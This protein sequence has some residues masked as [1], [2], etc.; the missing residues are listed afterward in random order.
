MAAAG[1]LGSDRAGG[2]A[3]PV[4]WLTSKPEGHGVQEAGFIAV[5]MTKPPVLSCTPTALRLQEGIA[6]GPSGVCP[7]HYGDRAPCVWDFLH[8]GFSRLPRG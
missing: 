7:P 4:A 3:G 2:H 5:Q 8:N 1:A 6:T